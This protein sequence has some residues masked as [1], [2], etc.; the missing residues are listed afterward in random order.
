MISHVARHSYASNLYHNNVSIGL[1]AQNMGR[2]PAEIETYLK[3]FE[4][5]N[6]IKANELSYLTGQPDYI[7][8][9]KRKPVNEKLKAH[10]E[11]KQQEEEELLKEYGGEEGYRALIQKQ[12]EDLEQELKEKFGDDTAAKIAYLQGKNAEK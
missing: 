4:D 11:K 3:E 2:N 12:K 9:R 8:A 1:I 6:I 7:E 10:F 5:E